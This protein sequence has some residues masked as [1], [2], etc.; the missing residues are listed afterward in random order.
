MVAQ[1]IVKQLLSKVQH[2]NLI[3]ALARIDF[4]DSQSHW[5]SECV[6]AWAE[7]RHKRSGGA[8]HPQP[9]CALPLDSV[10][11]IWRVLAANWVSASGFVG[12]C[13]IATS[14][15]CTSLRSR[16][17][18][19]LM[20]LRCL[21]DLPTLTRRGR[22]QLPD[23]CQH[24]VMPVSHDQVDLG[25]SSRSQILQYADPAICALLCAGA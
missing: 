21:C 6:G 12:C 24:A 11:R 14:S 25:R 20:T 9:S 18:M 1:T 17:G 5:S 19:A 15:A 3:G 7:E 4:S 8:L 2:I 23:S 10:E 13:Q 16:L 22:K